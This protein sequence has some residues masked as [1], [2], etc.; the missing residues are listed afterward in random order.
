MQIDKKRL[1]FD[2]TRQQLGASVPGEIIVVFSGGVTGTRNI[3]TVPDTQ[4]LVL[5]KNANIA[6]AAM[7][8]IPFYTGDAATNRAL[9]SLGVDREASGFS[10]TSLDC[11]R[12]HRGSLTSQMRTACT[13]RIPRFI[14]PYQLCVNYEGVVY[15][16]PN[17]YVSAMDLEPIPLGQR[18][19]Q[20]SGSRAQVMA[21]H[22]S[23][24]SL[25]SPRALPANYAVEAGAQ[26]ML[27]APGVDAIAAYDEIENR[28]E[29][30]A[31]CRRDHHQRV[32]RRC[33]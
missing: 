10:R 1:I 32:F 33:R 18:A 16:S 13:S 22:I 8:S 21:S 26:S 5:R 17:Y 2:L 31:W 3:L 9:A 4:L 23:G 24:M 29:S 25:S 7:G 12:H 11:R 20:R 19:I 28:F 30:T 14:E 27:N 6:A 15:A